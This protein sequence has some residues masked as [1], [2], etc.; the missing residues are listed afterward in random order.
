MVD[1]ITGNVVSVNESNNCNNNHNEKL[2]RIAKGQI[3]V[4]LVNM[5][6]VNI[7]KVKYSI[8]FVVV[9]TSSWKFFVLSVFGLS[10][11]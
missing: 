2:R 11:S 10:V 4:V 1:P 5:N 3:H 7:D 9:S 8:F 6:V